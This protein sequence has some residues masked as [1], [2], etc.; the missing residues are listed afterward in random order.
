MTNTNREFTICWEILKIRAWIYPLR[1]KEERDGM[2][3]EGN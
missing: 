1:Y 3:E 2:I